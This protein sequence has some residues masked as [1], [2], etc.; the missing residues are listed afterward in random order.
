MPPFGVVGKEEEC[1]PLYSI[2]NLNT[3]ITNLYVPKIFAVCFC[4][5]IVP[6]K[7]QLTSELETL[8]TAALLLYARLGTRG[9][10]G[11][12]SLRGCDY[13]DRCSLNR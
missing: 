8:L 12:G 3:R 5:S 2:I 13:S 10:G 1:R 7:A 11:I 9:V 6:P 4:L